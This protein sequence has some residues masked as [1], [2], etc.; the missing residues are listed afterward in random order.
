MT[1]ISNM[2]RISL[3]KLKKDYGGVIGNEDVAL[4][5]PYLRMCNYI[6]SSPNYRC[7]FKKK[8]P[9]GTWFRNQY[10]KGDE[11]ELILKEYL[12]LMTKPKKIGSR[13][14]RGKSFTIRDYDLGESHESLS[15]G[16]GLKSIRGVDDKQKII[17]TPCEAVRIIK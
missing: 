6:C 10:Y 5:K 17:I 11:G 3:A 8:S 1:T 13:V 9:Q 7:G 2:E 16:Y 15:R 14:Y 4:R 12:I